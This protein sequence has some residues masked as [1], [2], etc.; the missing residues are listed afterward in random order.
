M[1]ASTPIKSPKL[2][3]IRKV[4]QSDAELQKVI[5]FIRKGWPRNMA[6]GSPLRGYYA[7]RNHL[8]ELDSLVLYHDRI[9]VPAVLRAGV[10][11]QLH[12]GHQG[13]T[14]CRERAKLTVWWPSIGAQITNKVKLCDFCR[15][16]KP[17][18]RREPLVTTPLPSGP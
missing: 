9:V 16:H 15:E 5:T 18:Q 7:A 10:L 12:E 3:E 11:D 6:E 14:K 8:S 4:T 13:L 1:V 2:E 17:T